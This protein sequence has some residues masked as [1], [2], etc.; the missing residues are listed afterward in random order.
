VTV[1]SLRMTVD[2]ADLD[3]SRWNNLTGTSGHAFH[4][5][6]TDQTEAWQQRRQTPWLFSLDR[7]AESAPHTLVLTPAG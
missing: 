2:L 1:P 3:A 5:N 7:I 4:P 6:Y